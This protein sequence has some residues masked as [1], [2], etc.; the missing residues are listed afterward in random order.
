[1]SVDWHSDPITRETKVD[2]TFRK[3]QN[4]RRAL[5]DICG[6]DF[7]FDHDMIAFVDR[8]Q[9]ETIGEIA[10][11]WQNRRAGAGRR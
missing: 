3:T 10:D 2:S 5:M 4:V 6:P 1:M 7:R 9:P 8:E 11:Y